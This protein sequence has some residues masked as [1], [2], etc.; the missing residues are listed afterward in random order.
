[1][2]LPVQVCFIFLFVTWISSAFVSSLI[3]D[4]HSLSLHGTLHWFFLLSIHSKYFLKWQV[5]ELYVR[6]SRTHYPIPLSSN[7]APDCYSLCFMYTSAAQTHFCF[8]FFV[9]CRI[10]LVYNSSMHHSFFSSFIPSHPL[11]SYRWPL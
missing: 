1:M 6:T 9:A 5:S 10:C 4:V 3:H 2:K 7:R 8:D 11:A